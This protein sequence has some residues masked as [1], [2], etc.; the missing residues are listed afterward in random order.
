LYASWLFQKVVPP[1]FSFALGSLGFLTKFDFDSF[2]ESLSS[3][4]RD[5]VTV[6]LR[7]RF[8]GQSYE[9]TR[10]VPRVLIGF[11]GIIMRKIQQEEIDHGQDLIEKMF[12]SSPQRLGT[13]V[14]V[15]TYMV[16]NEIVIDRGPNASACA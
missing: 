4:I 6:G 8:E 11:L 12:E 14:P 7:L 13:H 5:G 10:Y 9:I 1:V 3:A 2:E 15:E 16:L